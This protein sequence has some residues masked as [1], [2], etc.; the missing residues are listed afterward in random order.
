MSV[1]SSLFPSHSEG[2]SLWLCLDQSLSWSKTIYINIFCFSDSKD[3]KSLLNTIEVLMG[4]KKRLPRDSWVIVLIRIDRRRVQSQRWR[5]SW[6][7]SAKDL[8]HDSSLECNIERIVSESSLTLAAK[9]EKEMVVLKSR[10]YGCSLLLWRTKLDALMTNLKYVLLYITGIS[11]SHGYNGVYVV[12]LLLILDDDLDKVSWESGMIFS[13]FSCQKCCS[14]DSSEEVLFFSRKT[15]KRAATHLKHKDCVSVVV[16]KKKS[17]LLTHPL[18]LT[19]ILM[20]NLCQSHEGRL[21]Q[22]GVK[23]DIAKRTSRL[24]SLRSEGGVLC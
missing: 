4:G 20:R 16:E 17:S 23:N 13:F 19:P 9:V 24:Q 12:F 3:G 11:L 1:D 18:V 8:N 15:S 10:M 21:S 22:R 6:R 14:R 7:K 2:K 5:L